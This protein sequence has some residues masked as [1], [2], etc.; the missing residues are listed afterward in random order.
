MTAILFILKHKVWFIAGGILVVVSGL[1]AGMQYYRAENAD[2][3]RSVDYYER[4]IVEYENAVPETTYVSDTLYLPGETK[5]LPGT[6]EKINVDSLRAVLADELAELG[7]NLPPAISV[8]QKRYYVAYPCSLHVMFFPGFDRWRFR[9][10][11]RYA[12][13]DTVIIEY[14]PVIVYRDVTKFPVWTLEAGAYGGHDRFGLTVGIG[15]KQIVGFANYDNY[16]ATG[17]IK[18]KVRL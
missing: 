1:Y 6:V 16:G 8:A 2:S 13:K 11:D 18:F 4:I 7:D 9:E 17:G 3:Q 5:W 15:F 10:Y 14:P 12:V